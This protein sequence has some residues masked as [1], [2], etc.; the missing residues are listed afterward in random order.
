MRVLI[1]LSELA[2][3]VPGTTRLPV[4]GTNEN[5]VAVVLTFAF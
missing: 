4:F 1:D 3:T 5:A 2:V